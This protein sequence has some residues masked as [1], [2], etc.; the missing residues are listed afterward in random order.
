MIAQTAVLDIR[1]LLGRGA[2]RNSYLHPQDASKLVKIVHEHG[3]M[4]ARDR[5]RFWALGRRL[6]MDGNQ[7]ELRS[8][9][10]LKRIGLYDTRF[11]PAFFGTIET[12]LGPGL[13]FEKLGSGPQDQIYELRRLEDKKL[14]LQLLPRERILQQYD[15]LQQFFVMAGFPSV[16]LSIENLAVLQRA[17]DAPQLVCFDMKF[18][19]DRRFLSAADWISLLYRRRVKRLLARK[20]IKFTI[21]LDRDL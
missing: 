19:E 17:G 20:K 13:V 9:E 14:A 3:Q 5:K 21:K 2:H 4:R 16:G 7:R 1:F 18:L 6:N 12:N 11:F 8:I 10:L 15:E